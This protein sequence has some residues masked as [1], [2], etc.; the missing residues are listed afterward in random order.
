MEL[1]EEV[2]RRIATNIAEIITTMIALRLIL[3]QLGANIPE[4]DWMLSGVQDSPEFQ[5]ICDNI[6]EQLKGGL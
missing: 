1:T 5:Q 6:L 2:L 4:L 3:V